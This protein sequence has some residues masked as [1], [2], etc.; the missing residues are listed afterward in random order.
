MGYGSYELFGFA[1]RRDLG[2]NLDLLLDLLGDVVREVPRRGAVLVRV[3]EHAEVIEAGLAN[4]RQQRLVL[5]DTAQDDAGVRCACGKGAPTRSN[6]VGGTSTCWA[7]CDTRLP[8]SNFP[9]QRMKHSTRCPPS[10]RLPL[11][12]RIPPLKRSVFGPLSL[13]DITM[14][15]SARP[16]ASNFASS[17]PT[18]LSRFSIIA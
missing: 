2:W 3:R 13:V 12:P 7:I 5:T 16:S 1:L 17:R 11:R 15:F 18:L 8:A 6:N 9:G 10:K 4:E 14:V